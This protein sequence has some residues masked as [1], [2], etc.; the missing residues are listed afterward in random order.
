[1]SRR[2]AIVALP[3]AFTLDVLGAFEIFHAATR[4][5]ALRQLGDPRF[6]VSDPARLVGAA[7]AYEVELVGADE[8]KVETLSGVTLLATRAIAHVP[9]P[10]D[11][12]IVAGG[13]IQ[14]MLAVLK[15]RPELEL[16]LR[17]IAGS[18]RRIVSVCT[19]SFVLAELGLLENKRA[20]SH[21]AACELLQ[22]RH[23]NVRVEH[24]PIFTQDGGVYTSAGATTGMDLSLALIREDHGHEVAREIA[25]WLVL[26]VE[27]N[28][29]QPQ[30]SAALRGQ[31][32]D[33]APLRELVPWI[34]ENIR[35]DLSVGVLA[36]RVGMSIRNFARAFKRELGVT[37]VTYVETV[38]VEVAGRK[39]QMGN[40]S[41]AEIA[42]EAG[43]GSLDTLRRAFL[44]HTGRPPSRAREQPGGHQ[45]KAVEAPVPARGAHA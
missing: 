7:P 12:L 19:G 14:R 17:R 34:A 9:D 15:Q 32:V 30:L 39:L 10:V 31:D 24:E 25:R 43:F 2:V 27:R 33:H 1:L 20:T 26:Y 23:K 11:T 4:I 6:D 41:L 8:G 16:A 42:N 5:V 13:D 37:P 22:K 28:A 40:A 3:G 44:K 21:W 18:A 35:S 38:R 36:A 29:A 45:R